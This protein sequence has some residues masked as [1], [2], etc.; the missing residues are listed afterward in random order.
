MCLK[1][2]CPL[3][4]HS[5]PL[6][7]ECGSL[8][9]FF[10]ISFTPRFRSA[11]APYMGYEKTKQ[12]FVVRI[13]PVR[14]RAS[15]KSSVTFGGG[16]GIKLTSGAVAVLVASAWKWSS[17]SNQQAIQGCSDVPTPTFA[18]L[19]P[20]SEFLRSF[21]RLPPMHVATLYGYTRPPPV[22]CGGPQSLHSAEVFLAMKAKM[23]LC[24][25]M[26]LAVGLPAPWPLLVSTRISSGRSCSGRSPTPCCSAAMYL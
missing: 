11:K 9:S 5:G 1:K 21:Y 23:S 10:Y 15:E 8:S 24:S 13:E 26:T 17:T 16:S 2:L 25:S 4:T 3:S 18:L 7:V 22:A 12:V 19:R 6:S 14:P 20:T